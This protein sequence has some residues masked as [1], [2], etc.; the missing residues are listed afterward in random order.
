MHFYIL[1]DIVGFEVELDET[2]ICLMKA[3][4]SGSDHIRSSSS[5]FSPLSRAGDCNCML[6]RTVRLEDPEDLVTYS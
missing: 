6:F 5:Y 4:R 1:I 2:G 3:Q